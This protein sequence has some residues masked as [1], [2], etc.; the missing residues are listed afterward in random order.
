[1]NFP[2][3]NQ[4]FTLYCLENCAKWNSIITIKFKNTANGYYTKLIKLPSSEI[5]KS[6]SYW[7]WHKS[8][9]LPLEFLPL[10]L[11]EYYEDTVNLNFELDIRSEHF[12]IFREINANFS[13]AW[14]IAYVNVS[15]S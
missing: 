11:G 14:F 9:S 15:I 4:P 10:T 13:L 6:D 3:C 5:D 8:L 7:E 2:N 1:M 12:S